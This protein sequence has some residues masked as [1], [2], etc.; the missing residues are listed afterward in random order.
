MRIVFVR[1]GEPNYELD[2][3]TP[4]GRKQAKAA[5]ERLREEG[6]EEI[7]SSPFGR[8]KE[9]AQAASDALGIRPIRVLDF[10]HELYWAV[11]TGILPTRTAIP[12]TLPT[13]SP[14]R[15]GI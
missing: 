13:A 11:R 15:A 1:H 5:A 10:M 4:L 2:C 12:G 9:T 14:V 3:L 8:A 7:Y 6:I